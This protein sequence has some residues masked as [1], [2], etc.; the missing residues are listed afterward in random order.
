MTAAMTA[1]ELAVRSATG[2]DV[3]LPIA[4]VGARAHAFVIDWVLR[5]ALSTTWYVAGAL[6][7]NKLAGNKFSLRP[8]D[9]DLPQ[10]IY[11]IVLPSV[12]LYFLYH[13]VLEVSM[14]GRTPGKRWAGLRIMMQDG[15][16]ATLGALLTRN[17]FRLVDMFP[18]IYIFGLLTAY[19]SRRHQRLGDVA[20]GTLLVH[21]S[22]QP[23][24]VRPDIAI[25]D[26]R[27]LVNR[28]LVSRDRAAMNDVAAALSA[29]W[30]ELDPQARAAMAR[31]LL[32]ACGDAERAAHADDD[33]L[34]A[35]IAGITI[36]PSP[37]TSG[38]ADSTF[39][40]PRNALF[41]I[42]E[43]NAV[44]DSYRTIAT[45]VANARRTAPQ[46]L[47]RT[48][49]EAAYGRV[50]AEL[51]RPAVHAGYALWSLFRDQLPRS[52]RQLRPHIAWITAWFVLTTLAGWAMVNRFP[53]LAQLFASS[54][55]IEKVER[56]ELWTDGLLNVAPSSIISVQI[57]TNNIVVSFF[58]Y[59]TGFLFG[60]G[61]LYLI[62]TNGLMLGALFAL[63]R[64]HGIDGRLF[65]FV[66]AHGLVELSCICLAG[67]AGAAVGEALIRPGAATRAEAFAAA[68]RR[69][70]PVLGAVVVLLLGCGFI[71]GY[72][73]P[74]PDMPL[75]ARIIIGGGYFLLM[76]ALLQGWLF[77]RSRGTSEVVA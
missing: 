1:P 8:P 11:G 26:N 14:R 30:N 22:R 73:S 43:A 71:E 16:N 57:L 69:S 37:A 45:Q 27:S 61:S 13:P 42:A 7:Y 64:A 46:S 34:R 52:V 60:L 56:G 15:S 18:G 28:T 62:G 38:G 44:I 50:H 54:E 5:L 66:V 20:A 21:E 25:F 55:M 31:K 47:A 32:V 10:W 63:C 48:G 3:L 17:V 74:D 12:A 59:C 72:V 76:I 39:A 68:A 36:E 24:V 9:E 19:F 35:A 33:A 2:V 70:G 40:P 4:A 75:A 67:A 77:G 29:R 6:I 41:E 53:D 58:A 49:L 23:A 65:E 51:Q